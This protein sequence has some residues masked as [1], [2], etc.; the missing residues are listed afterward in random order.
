MTYYA[1]LDRCRYFGEDNDLVAIGWLD[2]AYEFTR[3]PTSAAFRARLSELVRDAWQPVL[4]MGPHFCP[5]CPPVGGGRIG[6]YRNLFVPTATRVYAAPELIEHYVEEHQYLP[7][8]EFI[9]AVLACPEMGS[10][11]YFDALRRH[12]LV[13]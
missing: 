8:P 6:G 5:Y 13:E 3:G 11:A 2:S 7:P 10:D 9:T 4:F 12:H 1:D